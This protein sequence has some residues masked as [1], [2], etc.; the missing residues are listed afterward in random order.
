MMN[1]I[2]R[3]LNNKQFH[4]PLTESNESIELVKKD[5]AELVHV[6]QTISKITGIKFESSFEVPPQKTDTFDDIFGKSVYTNLNE[7]RISH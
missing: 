4:I 5:F 3:S 6:L 1:Y 2:L 7:I